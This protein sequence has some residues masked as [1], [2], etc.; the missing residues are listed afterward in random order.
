MIPLY[1]SWKALVKV[2]ASRARL[3]MWQAC[4]S[5]IVLIEEEADIEMV[6][7]VA[8]VKVYLSTKLDIMRL[9]IAF[10]FIAL[11]FQSL[12]KET[13]TNLTGHAA[14][15]DIPGT[16]LVRY[17]SFST[18]PAF[19][20][21]RADQ[22]I[23]FTEW[24]EWMT[25]RYFKSSEGFSF[26]YMRSEEDQ[27]GMIHYRFQQAKDG[28]PL[29]FGIW[30]VHTKD[31]Q[32]ISMN[33]ELFDE[34]PSFTPSVTEEAALSLALA[35]V[36]ASSYKWESDAEEAHL[37][38]E[39]NDP[40]ATY[41]PTGELVIINQDPSLSEVS[42]ALAWKFNVYAAQPLSRQEVFVNATAGTIDF[43]N[44]LIH[45]A[46]SDGVANT[47][48]SGVQN[49]VADYTGTQFR[50]R[51]TGRGNGI[52]TYTMNNGTNYGAASD[53]TDN[54]NVW[55][56]TGSAQ[57]GTDA[58][59]GAEMTYDYFY[60]KHARNSIDDAGFK[61]LSYCSYDNNYSNAF[62]DGQRMT[63]GDG[64]APFQVIDVVGHEI[65]HGLTSNTADLVYSYESGALNESFSDIF[66]AAVEFEAEGFSNGDWLMGED[67]GSAIRSLSNP[68]QYGDPDT[69]FGTNWFAGA[70]D[71]GGVHTNSGVQ[72]HWFYL[73]TVGGTGTNDIGD[74]YS[75][76]ALGIDD[77]EAIAFRNLTI[78]LTTNSQYS[79]ARFYA[80]QSAQD[81]YG[82][83]TQEVESTTNAWYAVGVGDE[84]VAG[85]DAD[86][87]ADDT[88]DCALPFTVN[89]SN[90]SSNSDTYAWTFGDGGSSTVAQPSHTYTTAGTYTVILQSS[91]SCGS[92]TKTETSYITVGP[93]VPCDYIM[94]N[95][96]Q[97]TPQEGC[98]GYLY[99]N[100]GPDGSY[101]SGSD[102]WVTIAPCGAASVTINFEEF[103]LEAD[104]NC[105]YDYL[106][107]YDGSS[108]NASLLGSYCGTTSSS[109]NYP[110]SSLTSTGPSITIRLVADNG[111]EYSGFKISWEC[112]EG[113][114][115]P[116]PEFNAAITES[117]DG[118]I[119]FANESSN[120]PDNLIWRF[121][122]GNTS[123]LENPTHEYDSNGTYNVTLV[124]SNSN[125]TD[126]IIK[127]AY[128]D[129][130]RPTAPAGTNVEICPE[131]S[132]TLYA[133]P[134]A[135]G[136]TRWYDDPFGTSPIHIGDSFTTPIITYSTPYYVETMV[137]GA[138]AN[139]GPADN[140]IGG[141][142]YFQF[143]QS[144]IFDV[145][146]ETIL[147]TVRVFADGAGN[148]TIDFRDDNG[149]VLQ[150]T[151][152]NIPDG[153][154]VVPLNFNLPVGTDF[155]IGM[156]ANS[157]VNL[158]RNNEGVAYPYTISGV[159]SITRSS[160][161]QA[162]GLNHYYYFYDWE[163][164]DADCVSAKHLISA[165]TGV[166]TGID[167]VQAAMVDI[168]P[169]PSNG[170]FTISWG[171][172]NVK[173]LDILNVHGQILN[174]VKSHTNAVETS[175]PAGMYMVRLNLENGSIVKKV[176]VQ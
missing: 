28:F 10:L 155:S 2:C 75:V 47:G 23:S 170:Q 17:K 32:V 13:E 40:E 91:S 59:W 82:A 135:T 77:A 92:D 5:K 168:Y 114:T 22:T 33:G 162:G 113:N 103:V 8:C 53:Y 139:V 157:N 140:T 175:L 161:N 99:D 109:G 132:T 15:E 1:S 41:F 121:G 83:C 73:L 46:D 63:Y 19:I 34:V 150:S 80:I 166:C 67:R 39:Q 102:S 108:I 74:N 154:S 142:A 89:F 88:E 50:L 87:L 84:Y 120:C 31:G 26:Q 104:A 43:R 68:N 70:G 38:L 85:V 176:I 4:S 35:S 98:L 101:L 95:S 116:V 158:Y 79:D 125:G 21:F 3:S 160:A 137:A 173:N 149:T 169:N 172:L 145:L 130:N 122:D 107:V 7:F 48:Y 100:G 18:V 25:Q 123:T 65:S 71:N 37:K 16:E 76:T 144:L 36:G 111:L 49:I 56:A 136:E 72:N 69:Y 51:E 153:E 60:N 97:G 148:R 24:E 127:Q 81:L 151:T 54:D 117:C 156:N 118:L 30:I 9:F 45:H 152:V 42:L 14:H 159:V 11:S 52:E 164:G 12:A 61:L 58:H 78:Y 167:E 131:E 124:V 174:S 141:G 133:M 57:Y 138:T 126:S 27:L 110:P 55:T 163:V 93:S 134:T 66:G 90:L 105:Q 20:R 96:G 6:L 106:E 94:V 129:I 147:K 112:E 29:E 44:D 171:E 62:W 86:F 143:N 165:S 64:G 119:S 115:P 128:I 146:S